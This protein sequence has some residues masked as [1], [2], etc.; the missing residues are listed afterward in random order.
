MVDGFTRVSLNFLWD[1]R[2][3]H[4]PPQ[5]GLPMDIVTI[6]PED[7][8]SKRASPL[9]TPWGSEC[10]TRGHKS[11]AALCCGCSV[12]YCLS[13]STDTFLTGLRIFPVET[14]HLSITIASFELL[15]YRHCRSNP[16]SLCLIFL[17]ML[18]ALFVGVF[19]W[20]LTL[21]GDL[22]C[23]RQL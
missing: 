13:S 20:N 12:A 19:D 22:P 1:L 23:M 11:S 6:R 4:D 10:G 3:L 15:G 14:L 16:H 8:E 2:G 5:A 9:L 18:V 21:Q 17:C 7:Q